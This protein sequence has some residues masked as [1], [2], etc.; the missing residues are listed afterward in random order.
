MTQ[1][2]PA[3]P[4]HYYFSDEIY[5]KERKEIY[6]RQWVYMRMKPSSK[7]LGLISPWK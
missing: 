7:K 2:V 1:M 5:K 6:G 3:V 4:A